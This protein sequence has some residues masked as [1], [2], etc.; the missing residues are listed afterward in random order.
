[1]GVE[2]STLQ[3]KSFY[4]DP[5]HLATLPTIPV[6]LYGFEL[7]N[8]VVLRAL[9]AIGAFRDVDKRVISFFSPKCKLE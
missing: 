7:L 5:N 6:C 3:S 4:D 8:N 9:A 2:S 1:M